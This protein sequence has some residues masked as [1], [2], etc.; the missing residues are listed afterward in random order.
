MK[1]YFVGMMSKR[2][3]FFIAVLF[4]LL[5]FNGSI[6]T[7]AEHSERVVAPQSG[8]VD[9]VTVTIGKKAAPAGAV[10]SVP[11]FVHE[12]VTSDSILCYILRRPW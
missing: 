11:I 6:T 9:T 10:F 4:L 12:D 2:T 3:I 7:C 8:L 1:D 5:L